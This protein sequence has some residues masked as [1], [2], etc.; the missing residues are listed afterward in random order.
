MFDLRRTPVARVLFPFAGG[1]V[2]GYQE[3]YLTPVCNVVLTSLLIWII[4]V[5]LCLRKMRKSGFTHIVSG[6][7]SLILF[8]VIGYGTGM[9]SRSQDPGMPEKEMV[10][11]KGEVLETPYRGKRNWVVDM[12][13]NMVVSRDSVFYTRTNLK[14]YFHMPADSVLPAVGETWQ[15]YGQFLSI[16]NNGNPGELDYERIM[17]RRNYWYRFFAGSR[18]QMNGRVEGPSSRRIRASSIRRSISEHWK[19]DPEE[20]SLLKAVCLGDRSGLTND[21]RQSYSTA[22]GMHLLAVS[23]L[24]VGLIWWVLR[25]SLAWMVRLLRRE[26]YRALTIIVLLWLYAF[27]AGFSSSVSRSVTMFTFF[28]ISGIIDQ[29]SSP[30]NGILVSAFILILINPGRILDVGFQLSYTAILG[31]VTIFPRLRTLW[32][33][34]NRILRWCWEA[35][36]VSLAAQLSTAPLVVYYFHQLPL[37]SLITNLFAI[38]LLSGMIALFVISIP[39]MTTGVITGLFNRLLV[40]MGNLM[41]RFMDFIA[42]IPGAK[43]G[44][45]SLDQPSLFMIMIIV[46]LG[47]ITLNNR[48]KLPRYVLLLFM[49]VLLAWTSW[50]R[51]NRIHSSELVVAHFSGCSLITFREGLQVEHYFWCQ[52]SVAQ[53]YMEQYLALRWDNR[54]FR[55]STYEICD[56]IQTQGI[57][58]NCSPIDP[59][60][61]I[62]GNNRIRGWIISGSAGEDQQDLLTGLQG[63]FILFSGEPPI[64]NLCLNRSLA[65]GSLIVDGSNQGWYIHRMEQQMRSIHFTGLQG[66][67]LK[68]W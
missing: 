56:S 47:M 51:Y 22:G 58:S 49:S 41:N 55:T 7:L 60:L 1:S 24:H 46:I 61:W 52:D 12:R 50:T 67:Y 44:E 66:A 59:G 38:P 42:S 15:L 48:D 14:V 34:K 27:I 53:T 2:A 57:I 45:L 13:L 19:G 64:Q 26:L 8:L 5:I 28:T 29:R 65:Q 43:I 3:I 62:V 35:T 68:R 10:M 21:M 36:A 20:V 16:R 31:I 17:H 33:V 6:I 40:L 4:L 54:R 23:G 63:D 37:Y 30:V 18:F 39:F 32:K 9:I 11:I 25:H